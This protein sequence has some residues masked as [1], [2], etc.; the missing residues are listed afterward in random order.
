MSLNQSSV[1]E[2]LETVVLQNGV[3]SNGVFSCN[4]NP[5]QATV[6]RMEFMANAIGVMGVQESQ[7]CLLTVRSVCLYMPLFWRE[8]FS[9]WHKM[10]ISM[11][12]EL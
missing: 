6:S 8:V 2:L 3:F 1:V 12:L 9:S 4:I 11:F 10:V 5:L 7:D